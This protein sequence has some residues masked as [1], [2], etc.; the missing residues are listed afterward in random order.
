MTQDEFQLLDGS[1]DGETQRTTW[2]VADYRGMKFRITA[3]GIVKFRSIRTEDDP[4]PNP[5]PG[6]PGED[7]PREPRRHHRRHPGV[8]EGLIAMT[9][10]DHTRLKVAIDM[11]IREASAV[12][13]ITDRTVPWTVD[14]GKV[15]L[16]GVVHANGRV[17]LTD[18]QGA[19]I[20]GIQTV[21]EDPCT[22]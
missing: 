7:L 9:P 16:T 13:A 14:S 10:D 22:N 19:V 21:C 5:M 15:V 17:E 2:N 4:L 12:A 6:S 3:N 11:A 20:E 18:L 1:G 8:Q